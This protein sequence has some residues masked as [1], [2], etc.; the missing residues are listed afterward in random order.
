[1]V[2]TLNKLILEVHNTVRELLTTSTRVLFYKICPTGNNLVVQCNFSSLF[3]R[4]ILL[5]M[6]KSE[7]H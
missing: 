5:N 2:F 4:W 1:M 6:V 7:R 3:F